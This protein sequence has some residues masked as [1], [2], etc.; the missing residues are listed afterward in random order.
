MLWSH[1]TEGCGGRRST[2]TS[3]RMLQPICLSLC[4]PVSLGFVCLS[5]RLLWALCARI[6][7]SLPCVWDVA[8]WTE[9]SLLFHVLCTA[10]RKCSTFQSAGSYKGGVSWL[11]S[12]CSCSLVLFLTLSRCLCLSLSLFLLHPPSFSLFPSLSLTLSLLLL[13]LTDYKA[14]LYFNSTQHHLE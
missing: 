13:A 5:L 2:E 12:H 1:A 6:P 7:V 3:R 8:T 14:P 4:L 11:W 10:L 9:M